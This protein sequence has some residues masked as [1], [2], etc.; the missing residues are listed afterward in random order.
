MKS[1][2]VHLPMGLISRE[3][4]LGADCTP[5]TVRAGPGTHQVCPP[6]ARDSGERNHR[7]SA[8]RQ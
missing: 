5:V 7:A 1:R 4:A 3:G 6:L 2:A 8:R